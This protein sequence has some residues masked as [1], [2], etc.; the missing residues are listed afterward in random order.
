MGD[1]CLYTRK[2]FSGKP[3]FLRRNYYLINYKSMLLVYI[4]VHWCTVVYSGKHWCTVVNIGVHCTLVYIQP[5]SS[6]LK[7]IVEFVVWSEVGLPAINGVSVQPLKKEFS[8]F[9]SDYRYTGIY[10][11]FYRYYTAGNAGQTS[12]RDK[13]E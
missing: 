10:T 3:I 8:V 12:D 9:R 6:I 13:S 1:L 5:R 11:P 4:G 2:Q 7:V